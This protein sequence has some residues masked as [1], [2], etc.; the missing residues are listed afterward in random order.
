MTNLCTQVNNVTGRRST[1]HLPVA[2]L[3]TVSDMVLAHPEAFRQSKSFF[4]SRYSQTK[5][6]PSSLYYL[7]MGR[8]VS[9]DRI[10]L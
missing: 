1:A 6:S 4:D 7:E 3:L 8:L 9:L 5:T 2:G 10:S